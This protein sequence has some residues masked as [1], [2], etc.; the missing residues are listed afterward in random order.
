VWEEKLDNST[1]INTEMVCPNPEC[2]K[3]VVKNNKKS[4]DRYAALKKK[5]EQRAVNRKAA[6]HTH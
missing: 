5:S 1:I 2:Q 6:H 4:T 3:E